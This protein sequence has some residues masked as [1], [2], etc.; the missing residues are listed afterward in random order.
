MHSHFIDEEAEIQRGKMT[1]YFEMPLLPE[2]REN[3]G[4]FFFNCVYLLTLKNCLLLTNGSF[5]YIFN[6]LIYI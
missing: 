1:C 4:F 3:L 2:L 5:I 6:I